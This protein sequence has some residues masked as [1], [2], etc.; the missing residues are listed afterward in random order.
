MLEISLKKR[1]EIYKI[2][3]LLYDRPTCL[4][5]IKAFSLNIYTYLPF[6]KNWF[7]FVIFFTFF[8]I[9]RKLFNE[10]RKKK[11][12]SKIAEKRKLQRPPEVVM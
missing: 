10:Q 2:V 3:V 7:H 5:N 12:N 1:K 8:H 11:K 6:N 9:I 4:I